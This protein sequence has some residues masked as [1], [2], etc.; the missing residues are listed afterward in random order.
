MNQAVITEIIGT[1]MDHREIF[2]I[3]NIDRIARFRRMMSMVILAFNFDSKLTYA[4]EHCA[5]F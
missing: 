3:A 2:T 5:R 1:G 4:S